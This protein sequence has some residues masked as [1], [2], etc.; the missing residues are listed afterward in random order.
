MT[1]DYIGHGTTTLF[2]ALNVLDGTVI[3]QCMARHRHQEFIRCKSAPKWN[4]VRIRDKPLIWR[5]YLPGDGVPIGA[6]SEPIKPSFSSS[7]PSTCA[8][9]AWSPRSM[10]IHTPNIK[11]TIQP[12]KS[13]Q[14]CY[15]LAL[16]FGAVMASRSVCRNPAQHLSSFKKSLRSET[17]RGPLLVAF[18]CGAQ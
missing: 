4:P 11:S 13:S 2:A 18:G 9:S 12:N 14:T 1:H 10:L 7:I 6:D 17:Q 8:V 16:N 15:I 3:G 5:L